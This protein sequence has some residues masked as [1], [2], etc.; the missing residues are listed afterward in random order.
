M[1]EIKTSKKLRNRNPK[2]GDYVLATKYNDGSCQDHF[3]VGWF[4]CMLDDRYIVV[5]NN[6]ISFRVSGFRRCEKISKRVGNAIVNVAALL[7]RQSRHSV[8]HWRR[9][10]KHLEY[11]AELYGESEKGPAI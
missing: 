4:Q 9:R 6:G 8:W 5:D 10:V 7:E 1:S 11:L 2:P 3:C